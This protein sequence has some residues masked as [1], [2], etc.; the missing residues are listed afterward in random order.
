MTVAKKLVVNGIA[1]LLIGSGVIVS[2]YGAQDR[3]TQQQ[4]AVYLENVCSIAAYPN[5]QAEDHQWKLK[6]VVDGA[7]IVGYI[8]EDDASR[9][10]ISIDGDGYINGMQ[11]SRASTQAADDDDAGP[12]VQPKVAT[13]AKKPRPEKK[14]ISDTGDGN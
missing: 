6:K 14:E 10:L 5:D 1:G 12:A 13:K 9:C 11:V 3:F 8:V 7:N 2:A 4:V